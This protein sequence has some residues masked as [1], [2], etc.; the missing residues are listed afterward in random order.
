M[1]TIKLNLKRPA[2]AVGE[3]EAP[4]LSASLFISFCPCRGVVQRSACAGGAKLLPQQAARQAGEGS[5]VAL[6]E[7]V[8]VAKLTALASSAD[9]DASSSRNVR[10][11]SGPATGSSAATPQVVDSASDVDDDDVDENLDA[12]FV[13]GS[14][15]DAYRPARGV[16]SDSEVEEA[17]DDYS[18]EYASDVDDRYRKRGSKASSAKGK[19]KAKAGA[20]VKAKAGPSSSTGVGA[21]YGGAEQDLVSSAFSGEGD[22]KGLALKPD[23][24]HRPLYISPSET[25]RTIV[26]EAFHPLAAQAQDFLIAVSEP[27]SR[28]SHIH[29]YRLTKH[30]LQA[31]ISVGLETEDIIEVLNRLSKVRVSTELADFIRDS[32]ASYGKV[33][34][35]LKKNSYHVESADPE[36][37]RIL[38]RDDVIKEARLLPED[39]PAASGNKDM[40]TFGLNQETA[41]KK[42]GLVIPGTA[43]PNGEGPAKGAKGA[44][45]TQG[46]TD[47]QLF[48]AIIGVDNGARPTSPSAA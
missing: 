31:A 40:V 29:E 16:E 48:G 43:T 14:E 19:G 39:Q 22:Y 17:A 32:T 37:L 28:P 34:L 35:V 2:S 23:H 15:E 21:R 3:G 46:L 8:L 1:P 5:R 9:S 45:V 36:V 44:D 26:L 18:S 20:V 7:D 4:L 11:K 33:K 38:L 27:V 25:N 30:S 12:A 10:R 41:P 13:S 24:A 47:D 6:R 42:G